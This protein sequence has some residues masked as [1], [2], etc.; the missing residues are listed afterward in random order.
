MGYHPMV[1]SFQINDFFW[2]DIFQ[3]ASLLMVKRCEG[4]IIERYISRQANAR[5]SAEKLNL[6]IGN[7]ITIARLNGKVVIARTA[8]AWKRKYD[9]KD[10]IDEAH[11]IGYLKKDKHFV[12]TVLMWAECQKEPNYYKVLCRGLK[13]YEA[14]RKMEAWNKYLEKLD[15]AKR[16][17]M[18]K[19][20]KRIRNLRTIVSKGYNAK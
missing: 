9:Y 19:Q 11:G 4:L 10:C 5:V 7:V 6:M 8:S 20:F 2:F 12:D 15:P 13:P 18:V 17:E 1:P 14:F 3:K 16:D